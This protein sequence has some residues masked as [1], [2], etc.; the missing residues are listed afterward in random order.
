MQLTHDT[1]VSKWTQRF[2]N[3]DSFLIKA[4]DL[5][6]FAADVADTFGVSLANVPYYVAGQTFPAGYLVRYVVAGQAESFFYALKAG[7]LP[8]PVAGTDPNWKVVPG[9]VA[10]TALSQAVTLREAQ[11]LLPTSVVAGRLYRIAW[12]NNAAGKPQTVSVVGLSAAAFAAFGV[13]EVNGVQSQVQVNVAAGSFT[14]LATSPA[15]ASAQLAAVALPRPSATQVR[16]TRNAALAALPFA[17][18]GQAGLALVLYPIAGA[19]PTTGSGAS[20]YVDSDYVSD[21]YVE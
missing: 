1:F 11:G 6:E 10:A 14:P 15:A 9:P 18:A 4:A 2:P 5:R 3:N 17:A 8:A 7:K 20:N 21:D 19:S 13:L 12:G 16:I